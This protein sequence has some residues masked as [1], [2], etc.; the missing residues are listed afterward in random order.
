MGQAGEAEV[1]EDV[2]DS[3]LL[4]LLQ[5]FYHYLRGS[6]ERRQAGVVPAVTVALAVGPVLVALG[7]FAVLVHGHSYG[8]D[9]GAD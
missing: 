8:R 9:C 1:A 3:G 5:A 4:G 6:P 2:V 7:D